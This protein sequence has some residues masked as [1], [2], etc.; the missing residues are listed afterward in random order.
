MVL[1]PRQLQ[2]ARL[3]AQGHT[4]G[5]VAAELGVHRRTVEEHVA[6]IREKTR[7]TTT[8]EAIPRLR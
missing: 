1:T 3:L 4:Q 2:I 5:E 6:R 8:R 7:S